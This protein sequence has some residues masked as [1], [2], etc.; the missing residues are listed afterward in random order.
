[1]S[2]TEKFKDINSWKMAREITNSIYD[3]SLQG[4]FAKDFTSVNQITE[5]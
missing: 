3:L 5:N 2:K 1:M 4:D